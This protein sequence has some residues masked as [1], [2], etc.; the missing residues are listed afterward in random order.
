M[1]QQALERYSRQ[2][3]FGP[4]GEAGQRKIMDCRVAIVGCGALGSQ[5]ASLLARAGVGDLLIIDRDFVEASNLQRQVL[6]DEQDAANSLPKAVAAATHLEKVN[7]AIRVRGVVGDVNPSNIQSL[8]SG[9]DLILDGTDNFETRY[10]LNDFSLSESIPWI[11]GAAVG[12][13]G[14]TM[15]IRPGLSPCLTCLFPSPPGGAHATCDTEGI[16][17]AVISMVVG[18]QVAEALKLLTGNLDALHGKLLHFDVWENRFQVVDTGVPESDCRA[19][20][21]REFDYL[22]GARS[23]QVTLCGRDSVQI[24]ER[25]RPVEFSDLEARLAPLGTVRYNRFLLRF[26]VD[27][28]ELTIFPDG[29]AIIKGTTD[30]GLARSLYSR[31]I[32][33]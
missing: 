5:Q 10:L 1:D 14:V 21:R 33:A 6:F 29:R 23:A 18:V 27:A 17:S 13:S 7:S 15:T 28:Y 8:L 2:I 26:A 22:S 25:N 32:G 11:Y 12:S 24:H 20:G 9:V 19:C 3:L 16:L 31:Y 30:A 4:I